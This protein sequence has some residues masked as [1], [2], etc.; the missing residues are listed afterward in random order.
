[1]NHRKLISIDAEVRNTRGTTN[2][3]AA[4]AAS[5]EIYSTLPL[6]AT[7]SILFSVHDSHHS[8]AKEEKCSQIFANG[9]NTPQTRPDSH[10][11][12]FHVVHNLFCFV[13]VFFVV[14]VF[15]ALTSNHTRRLHMPVDVARARC[16]MC[17]HSVSF[18]LVSHT[19][20]TRFSAA[21]INVTIIPLTWRSVRHV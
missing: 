19:F 1:M 16:E 20:D 9:A 6:R 4:S 5:A 7:Y 18:T 21:I 10:A 15:I 2:D 3:T 8:L 12:M 11:P 14:V 17:V 13:L